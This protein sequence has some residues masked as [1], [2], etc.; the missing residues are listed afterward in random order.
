M[1]KHFN[2]RR[3]V[4]CKLDSITSQTN[5]PSI[6][7]CMCSIYSL[8]GNYEQYYHVA[9]YHFQDL[10]TLFGVSKTQKPDTNTHTTQV[11]EHLAIE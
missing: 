6:G 7:H 9:R 3:Y 2:D 1:Y 11:V 5:S 4:N 8:S 10:A